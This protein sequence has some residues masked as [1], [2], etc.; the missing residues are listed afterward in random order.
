MDYSDLIL[1]MRNLPKDKQA[2]VFEFVE[3]RT[4]QNDVIRSP[5]GAVAQSS[6]AK[7]IL[8]PIVVPGFRPMSRDDANARFF[9][10]T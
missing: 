3:H 1:H 4:Q 8:N 5:A 7:W 9:K 10:K 2:K 6:L